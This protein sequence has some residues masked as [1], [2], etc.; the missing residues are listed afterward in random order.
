MGHTTVMQFIRNFSK[1]QFI[2]QKQFF[3]FLNF[4]YDDEMLYG[5][6]FHLLKYIAKV[7]IIM[8]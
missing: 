2:V 5:T 3:Y 6:A 7:S 1:V 8:I 4:M